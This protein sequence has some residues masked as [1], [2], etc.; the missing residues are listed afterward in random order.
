MQHAND[1]VVVG[2]D[3][4]GRLFGRSRWAVARWIRS[5]GFP[6]ARLPDGKWFTTMGMI[7]GWALE[8]RARDPLLRHNITKPETK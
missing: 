4:I 6:A 7:E 1:N 8:R 2:L 5:H 3:Q